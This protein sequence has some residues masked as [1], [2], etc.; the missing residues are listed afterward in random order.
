MT[1]FLQ[2]PTRPA[3]RSRFIE[4]TAAVSIRRLFRLRFHPRDGQ[5]ARNEI[6][7][8]IRMVRIGRRLAGPAAA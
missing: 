6:R 2:I 3:A 8:W 7:A 5:Q 4:T 1:S